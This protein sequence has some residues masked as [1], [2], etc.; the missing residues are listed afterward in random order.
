M[1]STKYNSALGKQI[2]KTSI[3]I[4][5]VGLD[6]K[7]LSAVHLFFY[8]DETSPVASHLRYTL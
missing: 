1:Y 4:H 2:S 7:C 5:N 3:T 8:L 6:E